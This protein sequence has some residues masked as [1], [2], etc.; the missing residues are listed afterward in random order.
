MAKKSAYEAERERERGRERTIVTPEGIPLRFKVAPA[1]ERAVAFIMDAVIIL[2]TILFVIIPCV[3]TGVAATAG[4]G[5]NF[6]LAA[7]IFLFFLFR[8]F[9]FVGFELRWQGATPGKRLLGLRVIDSHGGPLRGQAVFAR[10]LTRELELFLP[11]IAVVYPSAL[12][13]EGGAWWLQL[14][15]GGWLVVFAFMPLFNRDRLRV[16]DLI[17]GTI[18]VRSPK[19]VLMPD[20]ARSAEKRKARF[21]FSEKQLDMYGVFELQVLEDVLRRR[22]PERRE[23]LQVVADK[24]M[25]KIAW[26]SK[27]REVDPEDFL[28]DF[29]NAQR[30]RLEQKMVVAGERR[31]RKKKGRLVRR[32]RDD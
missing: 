4:W 9:F 8:H 23:S 7:F 32:R 5:E 26:D 25:R 28:R 13:G 3:C 29:Y 24:I 15:A 2:M 12:W 31:E 30:A 6:V 18:V 20:L 14:L 11:L 1:G 21:E 17:A 16:G 22:G 27:R 10:N 19:P